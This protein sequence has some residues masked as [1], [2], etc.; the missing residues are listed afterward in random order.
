[1]KGSTMS[2]TSTLVYFASQA[3][4]RLSSRVLASAGYTTDLDRFGGPDAFRLWDRSTAERQQSAWQQII[5]AAAAGDPRA[6]VQ[7][8]FDALATPPAAHASSLLEVGCGGG[9][10]SEMIATRRPELAYTGVDISEAMVEV[11]RQ[12]YPDRDVRVGSAYS[13][14]FGDSSFDIVFDG[15]A[16]IHMDRWKRSIAEYSRVAASCVIL[17]GL[18]VTDAAPTTLFA[19]YAYGQPTREL[20]LARDD[21]LAECRANDLELTAVLPGLDYDLKRYIGVPS[22]S[23]TWVLSVAPPTA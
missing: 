9:H 5:A 4:P 12:A 18:T 11:A 1:M 2:L 8:M 15:V 19:K 20:V 3:V 16:L 7:A 6:D 13:L 22:T 14:D 23:E 21:L 17:H 10:N